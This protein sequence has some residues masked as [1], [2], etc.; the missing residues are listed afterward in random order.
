MTFRTLLLA[1]AVAFAS[2]CAAQEGSWGIATLPGTP[3]FIADLVGWN[4]PHLDRVRLGRDI[5]RV[6]HASRNRGAEDIARL[7]DALDLFEQ[8]DA[9]WKKAAPTGSLQ[10][11][12]ADRASRRAADDLLDLLGFNLRVDGQKI[13]LR[14]AQNELAVER[15]TIF[16]KAG[17]G[18]DA[19]AARIQSGAPAT[20]DRPSFTIPLPLGAEAWAAIIGNNTDQAFIAHRIFVNRDYALG[21]VG[22]MGL[23]AETLTAVGA[24]QRLLRRLIGSSAPIFAAFSR[25][26]HI[27]NGRVVLPGGA[28]SSE[29][30]LDIVG[31]RETELAPFLDALMAGDKGRLAWFFDFVSQSTAATRTFTL[32][33]GD[34]DAR[35]RRQ[36]V[37]RL[38][39]AFRAT[40]YWN[41]E[42]RPFDRP[43][44]DPVLPI[45][46][47]QLDASGQPAGPTSRRFWSAV[48]GSED[49]LE[50][51]RVSLMAANDDD[52]IGPADLVELAHGGGRNADRL[53]AMAMTQAV[54]IRDASAT[55]SD[56]IAIA[57]GR[58]RYPALSVALERMPLKSS[59]A[60]QVIRRVAAIS[61]TDQTRTYLNVTQLQS[62]LAILDRLAYV[63]RLE[64]K[65]DDLVS[66]LVAIPIA[67]SG[68]YEGAMIGWVKDKLLPVA[69]ERVGP[70]EKAP[71]AGI[72]E[73]TMQ[74]WLSGMTRS[75]STA[76]LEWEGWK[77]RADPSLPRLKELGRVRE[78][79]QQVTVDEL[80][81]F[82][83]I[84]GTLGSLNSLPLAR[85]AA[86]S[87]RAMVKP[88]AR[89]PEESVPGVSFDPLAGIIDARARRLEGIRND[90]DLR[91]GGEVRGDLLPVLDRLAATAL[92]ALAYAPYMG[93]PNG[94][95]LLAGDVGPRHDFG[96]EDVVVSRRGRIAWELP[97]IVSGPGLK[98]HLR[99]SVLA[100][101]MAMA[102][103]LLRD[104]VD[105][106]PP[107]AGSFDREDRLALVRSATTFPI[108]AEWTDDNLAA[109]A[110]A[111]G[112]GRRAAPASP[113][114]YDG[115]WEWRYQAT[116]WVKAHE[117]TA[118]ESLFAMTDYL[119]FGAAGEE[120][121]TFGRYGTEQM[122]M[123]GSL[124]PSLPPA[125]IWETA[126]GHV[127]RGSMA[128]WTP[129]LRLRI[130][131]LLVDLKLPAIL[132]PALAARAAA[133]VFG[134][135][136]PADP[137][138]WGVVLR[139]VV[140]L[141]R[142]D[143]ADFVAALTADGTLVTLEQ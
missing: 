109:V 142:D 57:R 34:K 99:G 88:F 117:P 52:A 3:R 80:V 111:I 126:L 72:A 123:N 135:V 39:D 54:A 9:A 15:R 73:W 98:W 47:W 115:R 25:S 35:R 37:R 119:A 18:L 136:A 26:I 17:V 118:A 19:F 5:A 138:D 29:V 51:V 42:Q 130:A 56:L 16:S 49:V 62:A 33:L 11:N 64:G 8:L 78:R 63:D 13:T 96:F 77:Y 71:A 106:A 45:L 66:S 60:A 128:S 21:Y 2:P 102:S 113:S 84:V 67:R 76:E 140:E 48:V 86:M 38:Y 141:T 92:R 55:A 134:G 10:F 74:A 91:R 90:G 143:V 41:I 101:D 30:W 85:A 32:S 112:R 27:S 70:P 40:E 116:A 20:L 127:G 65:I 89:V 14:Q 61:D 69:I 1:A 114:T 36:N 6:L 124:R 75:R 103:L 107:E 132:A 120:W 87:V 43:E 24:N 133:K 137:Y 93:D 79:Q 23:D 108:T 22:L 104:S 100:L 31:A 68:L 82:A 44:A 81:Q 94:P 28:A 129:D 95:L 83:D 4:T 131:E 122:P 12:P 125:M 59:T 46:A 105:G 139:R 110:A 121:R 97:E 50:N 58:L 7:R 53:Q